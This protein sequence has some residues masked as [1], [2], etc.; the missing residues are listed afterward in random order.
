VAAGRGRG[1]TV[2]FTGLSGAGKST[3]ARAVEER[4][5][6]AGRPCYRLDGDDLRTGLNADLGFTP[7]ARAENVRR[8]AEVAYLFADAGLVALVSLISPYASG[9]RHARER[10]ESS[11]LRFVEVYVATPLQVCAERDVKGLYA[12]AQS[13]ELAALTG[14]GAPYE[15]PTSA[16]V[17][18]GD[19]GGGIEDAVERVLAALEGNP[20]HSV[21]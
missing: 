17:V 4:L 13:G 16:E 3:L 11:G 2:W 9:R 19:D 8:V 15:P 5:V 10:H 12:Q 7:H 21:T 1:A 18:V 14:V 20:P 6:A